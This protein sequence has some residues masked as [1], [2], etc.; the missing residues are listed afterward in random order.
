MSKE[1]NKF[2]NQLDLSTKERDMKEKLIV[3]T[4]IY[5]Y[6]YIY[7]KATI[8]KG[9]LATVVEGDPKAPFLISTTPRCSG[10]HYSFPWISPLYPWY[11]PYNTECS[12]KK[13]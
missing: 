13:Y 3:I 9:K 12:V 5:I 7:I 4:N 8:V 1:R 6:I 10:G 2:A 11:V